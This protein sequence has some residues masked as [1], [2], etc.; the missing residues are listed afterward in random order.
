MM[1]NFDETG[2]P[3]WILSQVF[4]FFALIAIVLCMQA[5]T[6]MRTLAFLMAFNAL[7]II[8]TALLRDWLLLGICALGIVR[9]VLFIWREKNYPDRRDVALV[10]LFYILAVSL[11]L[12]YLTIDWAG[13]TLRITLAIIIQLMAMLFIFGAW[14]KGIHLIKI[15]RFFFAIFIVINHIFVRNYI[16][17]AIEV[18]CFCSVI[19]F[20]IRFLL[21]RHKDARI[22]VVAEGIE[23]ETTISNIAIRNE[24]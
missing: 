4:S 11:V 7:M 2:L 14:R 10:T 12:S 20:Y 23:N 13:G 16:A 3:I 19:V 18:F 21:K 6:K 8:S 17:I 22:N 15:V 9:D 5:K 1:F 24:K